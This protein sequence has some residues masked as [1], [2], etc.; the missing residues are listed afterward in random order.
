MRK[1]LLQMIWLILC[2][3][4]LL[5]H[6]PV[7]AVHAEELSMFYVNADADIYAEADASSLSLLQLTSGDMV[8]L[9]EQGSDWCKVRYQKTTGYMMTRYLQETLEEEMQDET[10]QEEMQEIEELHQKVAV[11]AEEASSGRRSSLF[12]GIVIGGLII[13]MFAAAVYRGI[14]ENRK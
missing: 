13:A 1:K 2:F 14:R 12:W 8:L 10:I 6:Q 3:V 4:C 11:E 9:L 7:I 5:C